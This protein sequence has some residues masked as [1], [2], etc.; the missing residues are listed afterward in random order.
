M[1]VPEVFQVTE[2]MIRRLKTV[3]FDRSANL[4]TSNYSRPSDEEI[5]NRTESDEKALEQTT[6]QEVVGNNHPLHLNIDDS[7]ILLDIFLCLGEVKIGYYFFKNGNWRPASKEE[8][9]TLKTIVCKYHKRNKITS[10][11]V[12]MVYSL[13]LP[14]RKFCD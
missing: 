2:I 3:Y 7:K 10:D 11:I 9:K 5:E 8:S 14:W 13:D 6:I 12:G 1:M 4:N